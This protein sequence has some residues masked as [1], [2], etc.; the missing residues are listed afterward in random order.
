ME[1]KPSR[2]LSPGLVKL[3]DFVGLT[4]LSRKQIRDYKKL[5][6]THYGTFLQRTLPILH[7]IG[8]TNLSD[9]EVRRYCLKDN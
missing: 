5:Y 9:E 1:R 8:L 4:N 3:L 7:R 2:I 6:E